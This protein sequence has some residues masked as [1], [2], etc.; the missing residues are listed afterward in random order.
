LACEIRYKS[1]VIGDLKKIEKQTAGRIVHDLE[2]S[3][4][5]NPDEGIPLKGQFKG[6][7]KYRIGDY[8]VVYTK[9]KDGVLILRIAHRSKAYQK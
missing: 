9:I 6:L 7:Y 2:S 3:L 8:R 5:A 4:S 1:S